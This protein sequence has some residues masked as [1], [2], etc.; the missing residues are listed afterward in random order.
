MKLWLIEKDFTEKMYLK[1]YKRVKIKWFGLLYSTDIIPEQSGKLRYNIIN[2]DT[3][4]IILTLNFCEKEE[5][6]F[7]IIEMHLG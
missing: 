7:F 2:N 6:C 3:L 5:I 1:M 4:Y